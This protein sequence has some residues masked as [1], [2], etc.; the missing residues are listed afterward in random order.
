MTTVNNRDH[1]T[2]LHA[3]THAYREETLLRN[4]IRRHI[5]I[6]ESYISQMDPQLPYYDNAN[7]Y[8]SSYLE[9]LKLLHNF[10]NEGMRLNAPILMGAP[11]HPLEFQPLPQSQ[12]PPPPQP[13]RPLPPPPPPT[14]LPG[15]RFLP[16]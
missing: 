16:W 10:I 14:L 2:Y 8:I 3:I 1:N 13:S 4:N 7:Y 12:D 15:P 5:T 11:Q 6:W 9:D